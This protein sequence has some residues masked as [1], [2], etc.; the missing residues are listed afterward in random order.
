MAD[1]ATDSYDREFSLGLASNDRDLLSQIND[2]LKRWKRENLAP[3]RNAAKRFLK[4]GLRSFLLPP[5]VLNVRKLRKNPVNFLRIRRG[6]WTPR[7]WRG[8]L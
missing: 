7:L 8:Y 5:V 6:G 4:P 2:A 3:A 1:V